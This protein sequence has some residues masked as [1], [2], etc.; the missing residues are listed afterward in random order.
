MANLASTY[1]KQGRKMEAEKLS[2]DVMELSK[3]VLGAGHPDTLAIIANLAT[4]PKKQG[5]W[6]KLKHLMIDKLKSI[7]LK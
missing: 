1:W 6:R 3:R 7:K 5:G 4:V 2:I